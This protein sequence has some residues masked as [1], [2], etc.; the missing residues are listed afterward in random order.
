V[1][2]AVVLTIR[3]SQSGDI[4]A[5]S[6]ITITNNVLKNVVAGVNAGA[7]DDQCGKAPYVNCHNAGSQARWYIANN[8]LQFYDPKTPGGNRNLAISFQ[9][10]YDRING[11]PGVLHDVVFQHNTT[12]AAASTPCWNSIFFGTAGQKPPF[13]N[14]TSNI[15]ILDNVLCRQ[16]TGEWGLQ[17][18]NG[19]TQYMGTQGDSQNDLAA[20]FSGNVMFAPGDTAQSWPPHNY[21]SQ[22]ALTFD[23]QYQLTSPEWSANTSDKRQAGYSVAGM[24]VQPT[25]KTSG[26][27]SGPSLAG[28]A[29]VLSCPDTQSISGEAHSTVDGSS[30]GDRCA[31]KPSARSTQQLLPAQ[32]TW[33]AAQIREAAPSLGFVK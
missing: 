15:W 2:Y 27:I 29:V 3:S 28:T 32:A 16:P 8:L 18:K 25:P 6:D 19:L 30:S 10:G 23:A 7:V 11:R 5:V 12:V 20:R 33:R 26:V 13:S 17:G 9:P 14:L 31:V 22:K 21:V 4:A 24:A 1:G